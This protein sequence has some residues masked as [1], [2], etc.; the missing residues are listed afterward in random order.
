M[1]F[2]LTRAMVVGIAMLSV[3]AIA[4]GCGDDDDGDEGTTA[5]ET[6]TET[7][8]GEPENIVAAAQATPE[9][10]TLVE[11]VTAAGLVET[12]SG[13][14][15]YTL[16]APTNAAFE[17][18]PPGQLEDLLKPANKQQLTD[19]LTY[20]VAEGEVLSSELSDGQMIP[21]L[22][23]EDLEITVDGG[24]VKVNGV[25]VERADVQTGNGVVHV[26]GE[27]LTPSGS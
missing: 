23:G 24:A 14:G 17:A 9:L 21:T 10:S 15:P 1:K 18:L 13:P 19:I 27:V 12:L 3:A 7:T 26:I 5:A 4:A 25:T 22:Q 16:F 2:K 11:A 6:T 8:A 20:H